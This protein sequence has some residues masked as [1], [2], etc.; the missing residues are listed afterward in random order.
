M[1]SESEPCKN[2]Q[3]RYLDEADAKLYTVV[4]TGDTPPTTLYVKRLG[5]TKQSC[6]I[7]SINSFDLSLSKMYFYLAT[8]KANRG[9]LAFTFSFYIF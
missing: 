2:H 7:F 6:D 4:A 5:C 8:M 1:E 9:L 3:H